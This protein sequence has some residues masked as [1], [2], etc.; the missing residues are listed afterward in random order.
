MKG[1]YSVVIHEK[2]D[3][4]DWEILNCLTENSRAQWKDIGAQVHLSGPAVAARV[5]KM[6]DLGIIEGFTVKT[7]PQKLG[8]TVAAMVTV[9]MKTTAHS[10]FQAFLAQEASIV[11]AHRISGGGCYFLK[12]AARS[13]EELNGVLDKILNYGNFQVSLSMGR[14]K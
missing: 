11:E 14:I 13:P 8:K 2:L 3:G 10:Q 5:Q 7:N 12:M 6:A 4:V 1:V 9:F